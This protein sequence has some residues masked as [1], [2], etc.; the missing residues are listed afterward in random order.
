M[1]IKRRVRRTKHDFPRLLNVMLCDQHFDEFRRYREYTKN[2]DD[3]T[4]KRRAFIDSYWTVVMG[5][6]ITT[7][8]NE[9]YPL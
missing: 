4:S 5:R 3:M 6:Y 9:Q 2:P 7:K 1:E 8:P